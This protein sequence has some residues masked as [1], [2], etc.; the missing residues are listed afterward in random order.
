MHPIL[1][2]LKIGNIDFSLHSY[3]VMIAIGFIVGLIVA[4]REARR[5]GVNRYDVLD[6]VFWVALAGFVGARLLF[7]VVNADQYWYACVDYAKFNTLFSPPFPL[8]NA[9]C[10][11]VFN[12]FS[13][14][15][16]W[17]GGLI[18][19]ILA[20]W[21][22]T[23]RRKLNFYQMADVLIP[24][25][26]LGHAFGRMGCLLAGCCFG[27]PTADHFP[28]GIQFPQG[29]MAW[30]HQYEHGI[31]DRLAESSVAV[32]PTQIYEAFGEVGI[33]FALLFLAR[34][35][36]F[37]GQL[38]LIYLGLYPILRSV[39]EVFRGD[40]E[41]GFVIPGVLSTSQFISLL[42]VGA[43]AFLLVRRYRAYRR[44]EDSVGAGVVAGQ[45]ED[46]ALVGNAGDAEKVTS[47]E[48]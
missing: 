17:Y 25:V 26:A 12:V 38:L 20:A 41:R 28:L 46:G 35:K 44:G 10:F 15:L 31:I 45:P 2:P 19:A 30:R 33:F 9:Q 22:F 36:A 37:H 21:L 8:E 40:A 16:V 7:I 14:G 13:G 48:G 29:S 27:H 42:V 34:R 3:G 18:G 11:E 32:H 24:S 4:M 47:D 43:S 6:T 23:R 39:I 5:T 1:L